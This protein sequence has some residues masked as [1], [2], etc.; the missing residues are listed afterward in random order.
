MRCSANLLILHPVGIFC[1]WKYRGKKPGRII[2]RK[3]LLYI[4][5][6]QSLV[7]SPIQIITVKALIIRGI[8]WPTD[9]GFI[10]AFI[11]CLISCCTSALVLIISA[12]HNSELDICNQNE[13]RRAEQV[14]L[15]ANGEEIQDA[16]DCRRTS[17]ELQ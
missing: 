8:L 16:D 10:V 15:M 12:C 14:K 13:R 11:I 1:L 6:W 9:I 5:D 17:G 4:Y 2:P 7:M 3:I